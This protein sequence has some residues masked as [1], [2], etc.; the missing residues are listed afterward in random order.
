MKKKKEILE[1]KKR[2]NIKTSISC[3]K[4]KNWSFTIK[5]SD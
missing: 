2:K 5:E 3:V 4:A 1:K